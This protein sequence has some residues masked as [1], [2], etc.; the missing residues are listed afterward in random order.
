MATN[1]DA[2]ALIVALVPQFTTRAYS[3][4]GT[5]GAQC[6][7]VIC[8]NPI[9]IGFAFGRLITAGKFTNEQGSELKRTIR[10]AY[11]GGDKVIAYWPQIKWPDN[12]DIVAPRSETLNETEWLVDFGEGAGG[13][14]F[15]VFSS[16][17]R[18][19]EFSGGSPIEFIYFKDVDGSWVRWKE[20]S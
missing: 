12:D 10:T 11:F 19:S 5:M 7:G 14:R 15:Q 6:V 1:I 4:P 13:S 17:A 2:R 20:Q 3:G 18:L 9:E 16:F 8:E